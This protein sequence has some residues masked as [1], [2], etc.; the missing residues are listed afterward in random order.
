MALK[1]LH[2]ADI[3][4]GYSHSYL[5]EKAIARKDEVTNQFLRIL[6]YAG[7][8]RNGIKAV[9]IAGDLFDHHDPE[10]DLIEK[11]LV[12]LKAL[13]DAGILTIT[14]PGTH[15]E[16]SYPKSVFQ[17]QQ[18]RWPGLLITNPLPAHVTT[19]ILDG[20]PCHIYGM[21]FTA[22]LSHPPFDGIKTID[23]PG[24]HIA[25]FHGTLDPPDLFHVK[26]RDVPLLSKHLF[27]SG[28]DYVALGHFH[29]PKIMSS[30]GCLI[31]YPGIIE[32]RGFDE[33]GVG[34][35]TIVDMSS[36]RPAVEKVPFPGRRIERRELNLTH[37]SGNEEIEL[38][39][40]ELADPDLILKVKL[41]GIA[42]F[43]P[44]LSRLTAALSP[45]FYH[46]AWEEDF[47]VF[48]N[49]RVLALKDQKIIEG[50]L[51]QKLREHLKQAKDEREKRVIDLAIRKALMAFER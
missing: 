5:K 37:I 33:P 40:K 27:Q 23:A 8:P 32:G 10:S 15:D 25:L 3:H 42:E 45:S 21:A 41:T 49:R 50:L 36:S 39:L 46:I 19:V 28:M 34:L 22:G 6:E 29:I 35:L 4:L 48:D 51:I 1:I 16:L 14:L 44:N 47:Y 38:R 20:I 26:D 24:K 13:N 12:A 2:L 43:I 31:V 7:D 30:Q 9:L 11:V 17:V 18:N